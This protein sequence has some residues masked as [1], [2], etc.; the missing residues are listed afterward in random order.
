MPTVW[1][2]TCP[3][4]LFAEPRLGMSQAKR[5]EGDTRSQRNNRYVYF[6]LEEAAAIAA[7]IA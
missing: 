3:Y 4:I 6:L 2:F 7:A 5:L 1:L